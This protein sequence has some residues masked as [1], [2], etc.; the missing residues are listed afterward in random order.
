MISVKLL[1]YVDTKSMISLI[2]Y[3][4]IYNIVSLMIS[5]QWLI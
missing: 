2:I 4:I 5:F 1:E 3:R